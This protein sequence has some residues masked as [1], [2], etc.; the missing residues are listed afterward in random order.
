MAKKI[1]K[2]I[3]ILLVLGFVAIQFFRIDKTN[4]Q[5]NAAD[6]MEA[7][8]NVPPDIQMILGR[9]CNDCHSNLT[10]YP[11]YTNIQPSGWFL[12]NHVDEGRRELNFSVWSTYNARRRSKKLEEICEQVQKGEMPLP[13]YLW[14]HWDAKLKEGEAQALCDWAKDEQS[15]I[16]GAPAQ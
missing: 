12:R 16:E 10:N 15:K 2:I 4:P 5:V 3:L 13:S 8:M 1:I 6:T 11:W 7:T 9:S 14:I